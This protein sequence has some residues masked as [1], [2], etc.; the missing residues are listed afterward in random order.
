MLSHYQVITPTCW[1][2]SPND[3]AGAL[4]PLEQALVGTPV[5][6]IDE[7]IEAL[8]IVHSFDPCLDCAVH[9]MRPGKGEPVRVVASRGG[10]A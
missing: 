3:A 6:K 7:P 4:G 8:R 9:V 10:R 1:N 2:V 5:E